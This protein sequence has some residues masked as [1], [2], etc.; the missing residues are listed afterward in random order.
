MPV[1]VV[2]CSSRARLQV[3]SS[4]CTWLRWRATPGL[5]MPTRALREALL[6]RMRGCNL[7]PALPL[8][9]HTNPIE[10]FTL[11][12]LAARAVLLVVLDMLAGAAI[13]PQL[14]TNADLR[15]TAEF[16]VPGRWLVIL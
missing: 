7:R 1:G 5:W 4:R 3:G 6:R 8:H 2:P 10:P 11:S 12:A 14:P 15:P 13:L 16:D 9:T